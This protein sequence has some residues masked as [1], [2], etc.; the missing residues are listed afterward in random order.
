MV[1]SRE[2]IKIA[3][4]NIVD[5][6]NTSSLSLEL[7]FKFS[8]MAENEWY[9]IAYDMASDTKIKMSDS[10]RASLRYVFFHAREDL[11]VLEVMQEAHKRSKYA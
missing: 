5:A 6:L 10:D 3:T 11:K 2:M 9:D 8:D 7:H 4:Y 1:R